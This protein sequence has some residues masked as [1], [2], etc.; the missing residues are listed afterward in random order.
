MGDGFIGLFCATRPL[1]IA[2]R[3]YVYM[4]HS[5]A[6]SRLVRA[7]L[8]PNISRLLSIGRKRC[9]Y[10]SHGQQ[11]QQALHGSDL[12]CCVHRRIHERD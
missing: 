6:A 7:G 1:A 11:R 10:G 8:S 2:A 4:Q 3:C 12:F 9:Q 5:I